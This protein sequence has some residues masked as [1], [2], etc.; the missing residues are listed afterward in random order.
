MSRV[1]STVG[2]E[3]G[4]DFGVSTPPRVPIPPAAPPTATAAA[5]RAWSNGEGIMGV[6][7]PERGCVA[8]VSTGRLHDHV[9][10]YLQ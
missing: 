1:K 3:S 10:Y 6:I 4:A 5:S 7:L 2:V 9:N 8:T